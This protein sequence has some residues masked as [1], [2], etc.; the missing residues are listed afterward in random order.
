MAGAVATLLLYLVALPVN[1]V[2]LSQI[3]NL[4]KKARISA[5]GDLSMDWL[6]PFMTPRKFR[7]GSVLCRKGDVA[8]EMFLVVTGKF[9]ITEL[10]IEICPGIFM[11]ELGFVAPDS[12]RTQTI[13]CIESG[14]VLSL[15]YEKLLELIFQ[16]PEFGYYFAG[17]TVGRLLQNKSRLEGLIG[18]TTSSSYTVD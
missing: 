18:T 12:R 3:L 9:L 1:V 7:R 13:R 15:S 16:S 17:L 14:K 11:G 6:R 5:Q 10:G 8:K 2:R 4:N